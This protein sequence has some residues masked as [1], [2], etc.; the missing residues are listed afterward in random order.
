MGLSDKKNF[1]IETLAG[2]IKTERV[3]DNIRVDMGTPVLDAEKI[4]TAKTSG[5]V[6]MEPV[7]VNEK[8]FRVTAV[9]MGNPHAVIYTEQLTDDLVLRYGS[10]LE[11]H[12]FF[13]NKVNVEFVKVLSDSEIEMRV[14]ERGCGETMACG[15]GACAICVAG[16]VT[17]R[18]DRAIEVL[19]PGGAAHVCWAADDHVYLTGPAV[20][21]FTGDWP[22]T[23]S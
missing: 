20:E 18:T 11:S 9:S 16:S 12:P 2:I 14:F 5:H 21:V 7:S 8:E 15:T 6:V 10:K 17:D 13:P 22:S 19:M 1:S 23:D 3:G 4:P